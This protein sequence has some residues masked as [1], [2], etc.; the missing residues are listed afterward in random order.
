M[1]Y[2]PGPI[3]HSY[4]CYNIVKSQRFGRDWQYNLRV[5]KDSPNVHLF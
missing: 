5:L 4:Y 3:V 1:Y 2:R